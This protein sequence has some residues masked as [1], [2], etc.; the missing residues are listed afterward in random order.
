MIPGAQDQWQDLRGY[1]YLSPDSPSHGT[2]R[3]IDTYG[4]FAAMG[5]EINAV[6]YAVKN[7]DYILLFQG[8]TELTLPDPNAFPGRILKLR[9]AP[10]Y[11]VIFRNYTVFGLW[12]DTT[13]KPTGKRFYGNTSNRGSMAPG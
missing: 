8:K 4:G 11:E 1:D 7:D 9:S 10:N 12:H 3:G 13:S 2:G 6:S 5:R